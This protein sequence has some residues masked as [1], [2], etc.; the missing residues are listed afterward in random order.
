MGQG[1]GCEWGRGG[2]ERDEVCE[3]DKGRGE[4]VGWS[5]RLYLTFVICQVFLVRKIGGTDAGRMYAMKVLKKASLKGK[6]I[7]SVC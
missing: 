2:G 3:W 6:E 5:V 7:L 1:E 4:R